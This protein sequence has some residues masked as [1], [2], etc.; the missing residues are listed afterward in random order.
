MA[1][2]QL[3]CP[4]GHALCKWKTG[5]L[6]SFF[7]MLTGKTTVA[8]CSKCHKPNRPGSYVFRCDHKCDYQLCNECAEAEAGGGIAAIKPPPM[9]SSMALKRQASTV[10]DW[11]SQSSNVQGKLYEE[12]QELLED[13]GAQYASGVPQ[14]GRGDVLLVV[15]MQNDFIPEEDAP[16]GGRFGVAEGA[17]AGKVI[18]RLI[19]QAAAA[20]ATIVATRDYH[21]KNHC[22]FNTHGGHFPPH[23]LQGSV[24]S[25]FFPPIE[26]A[27]SEARDK[28]AD[29]RVVFKGFATET[30]SFGSFTYPKAH[31]AERDLAHGKDSEFMCHGC[32]AIDW[33]GCFHL[34]CSAIDE[35]VNAPPDVM[36]VFS[37]KT[38]GTQLK[39]QNCK[40]LFCCGLALD[41]CVL[42]SALNAADGGIAPSGVFLIVDAAR[43]A[44]IPGVGHFG[45]G[46]LSD[47]EDV[48]HKVVQRNVQLVKTD[49]IA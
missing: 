34:E 25:K 38:L 12:Y 37:R 26:K 28:G 4:N 15:D 27:L 44:Y 30:D 46:F 47:P 32:A 9:A 8:E 42:D 20:G 11:K 21:P 19:A 35:D 10:K 36:A 2:E 7:A 43:S 24:G 1:A 45:T 31:F 5:K 6:G 29:V 49:A 40:R 33:T 48:V 17:D 41:F 22:S 23:C 39:E 14:F 3:T 16:G 18:V 13:A